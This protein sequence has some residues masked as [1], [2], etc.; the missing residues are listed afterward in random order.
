[1]SGQVD[2]PGDILAFGTV[3]A[4]ML[5]NPE[6]APG[7]P[8]ERDDHGIGPL[9]DACLT[10]DPSVRPPNRRKAPSNSSWRRCP[11]ACRSGSTRGPI[12]WPSC[13]P[14]WTPWTRA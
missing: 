9:I 13:A 2:I 8:A 11:R 3:L 5:A 12:P 14:N 10:G 1:M 4:E 7:G 6:H